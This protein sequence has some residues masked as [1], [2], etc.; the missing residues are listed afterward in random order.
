MRQQFG[1]R[2]ENLVAFA[3]Q[4]FRSKPR[5]KLVGPDGKAFKP[6]AVKDEQPDPSSSK[7]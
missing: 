1:R 6:Q 5:L 7:P 4:P 3:Q 2:S